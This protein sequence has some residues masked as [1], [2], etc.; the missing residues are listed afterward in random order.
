LALAQRLTSVG[1]EACDRAAISRA[2][3]AAFN[4]ASQRL[5]ID[6]IPTVKAKGSHQQV[7]RTYK[8]HGD[9]TRRQIA[10]DGE[11]LKTRRVRADYR[12]QISKASQEA[13]RAVADARRLISTIDGL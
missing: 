3:Y 1:D 4:V 13:Q 12:N 8:W 9:A 6:Q 5:T 11:R 7:W 2:Y 10:I